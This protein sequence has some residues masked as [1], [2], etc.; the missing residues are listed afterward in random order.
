M[1]RLPTWP[2]VNEVFNGLVASNKG[3]KFVTLS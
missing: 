1:K 3:Q 2:Q